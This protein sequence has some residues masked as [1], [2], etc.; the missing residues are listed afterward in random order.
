MQSYNSFDGIC[1]CDAAVCGKR[2]DVRMFAHA[3]PRAIALSKVPAPA[4]SHWSPRRG[5]SKYLRAQII[6][7]AL[8][9]VYI[10]GTPSDITECD[11]LTSLVYAFELIVVIASKH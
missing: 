11:M 8:T 10:D 9:Q 6:T 4:N 5:S 1:L 7:L 3:W 2:N